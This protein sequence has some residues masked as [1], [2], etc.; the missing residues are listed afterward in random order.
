MKLNF[1]N[2]QFLRDLEKINAK[3]L[4]QV[5]LLLSTSEIPKITLAGKAGTKNADYLILL[6]LE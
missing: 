6:L 3:I 5:C 4:E 2:K 1:S